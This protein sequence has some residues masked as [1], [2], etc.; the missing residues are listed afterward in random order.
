[1]ARLL[2]KLLSAATKLVGLVLGRIQFVE[3]AAVVVACGGVV[4]IL[5]VRG[6]LTYLPA[7]ESRHSRQHCHSRLL[8]P[9]TA[10]SLI[11]I[12]N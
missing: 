11:I 2:S 9:I 12:Y 8:H 4:L 7:L 6:D 10:D 1:V 5:G 3:I